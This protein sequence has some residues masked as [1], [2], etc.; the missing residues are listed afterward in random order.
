MGDTAIKW[1]LSAVGLAGV[2]IGR[3]AFGLPTVALLACLPGAPGTVAGWARLRPVRWRMVALRS[4][5]H[6][7][8]SL[9]WYVAWQMGMTLADS[10]AIGFCTPL[11]MTLLAVPLLGERI[12]WR[13][14]ASTALGF[15]GV[16]VMLRPG[17]ALWTPA[18][19]VMVVGIARA[20]PVAH[21]HPSAGHHRDAGVSVVLADGR[22]PAGGVGVV[23]LPAHP[24]VARLGA[25]GAG[26]GGLGNGMGHWLQSRAFALAPVGAL[27]PYEY[28]A[29]LWGSGLG[30]LVF[31]ELP[32]RDA[33]FG[34]V[35]VA[36][37]GLCS[38]HREQLRNARSCGRGHDGASKWRWRR[39]AGMAF[40]TEPEPARD[41]AVAV[42]PG[43]SRIVAANPGPMTYHGTNT[44][45]IEE[46][47]GTN[48]LDPGPD[49]AAHVGAILRATG[50]RV[51]RLLLSHGHRDHLGA[52]PALR[53][54]TGAPAYGFRHCVD[55]GFTPDVA[56]DDG[57]TVAGMTALHTPGHASDH[58]CFARA[59][60]VIFTADHVMS[61]STSVVAPPNGDM[62]A[63]FA[64]LR[65]LLGRNDRL[66]LPGHGPPLPRPRA[67]LL[68]LLAHRKRREAAVLEAIAA[69][70][71]TAAGLVDLLYPPLDARLRA[72]AERTVL[73]HL[74]KLHHEGRA[75]PHDDVW[76]A[77]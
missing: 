67:C 6:V 34:A 16:L 40:L 63:Y 59:D 26:A 29:L 47:D 12:R 75:E 46:P 25:G 60:G 56:L 9:S 30:W 77:T 72:A 42:A 19:L 61:W 33:L 38:F 5:V 24:G 37:A 41:I 14:A 57:D 54:A 31:H 13:R 35:I 69:A 76:H 58:L 66:L 71:A 18:A 21:P 36:A 27:A 45:L 15:A 51:A 17:G 48:V 4:V 2:L 64:S 32:T 11:L 74:L 43:V 3:A 62:A 68:D 70:P 50:G 55:P 10:Y 53:A 8:A 28:T 39:S 52:L 44:Y 1:S 49:D 23:G 7:F 73:A 22:P 20:G 65:R